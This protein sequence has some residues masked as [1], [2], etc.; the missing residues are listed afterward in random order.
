MKKLLIKLLIL[1]RTLNQ[2][3]LDQRDQVHKE[4]KYRL[5]PFRPILSAISTPIYKLAKFLLPFLTPFTQNE[6]T[7]RLISF[8]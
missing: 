5:P 8:C 4:T 7:V 1:I 3:G 2:L 6:Y